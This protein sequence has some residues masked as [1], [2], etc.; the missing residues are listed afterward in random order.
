MKKS[1]KVLR[2]LSS[3][4]V[5][6]TPNIKRMVPAFWRPV[7]LKRCRLAH[8]QASFV[9]MEICTSIIP[10]LLKVGQLPESS[11]LNGCQSVV[12]AVHLQKSA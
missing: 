8:T 2:N 7:C 10:E 3:E 12:L 4:P 5:W 9:N 11:F 6:E 1:A